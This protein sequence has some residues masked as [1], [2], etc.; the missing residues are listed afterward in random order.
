M[1]VAPRELDDVISVTAAIRPNCRSNGVAIDDAIVSGLAPGR[2]AFTEIVGKSTYVN[3]DTGNNPKATP[4]AR[5]TAIDSNVVAM[6]PRTNGSDKF[7]AA[8]A[9]GTRIAGTSS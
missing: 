7:M 8:P 4:P 2:L 5:A 9:P 1:P 6:G 3:G